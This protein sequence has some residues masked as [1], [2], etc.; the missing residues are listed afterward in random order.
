MKLNEIN[1][2][3]RIPSFASKSDTAPASDQLLIII[4]V[5][6]IVIIVIIMI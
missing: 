3:K 1:K 5:N 6:F 2:D 4:I